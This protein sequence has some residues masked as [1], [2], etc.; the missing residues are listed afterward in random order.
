MF[1]FWLKLCR[2]E[3]LICILYYMYFSLYCPCICLRMSVTIM[4]WDVAVMSFNPTEYNIAIY[5]YIYIYNYMYNVHCTNLYIVLNRVAYTVQVMHPF[6]YINI[7]IGI[8]KVE[9]E[10]TT[11]MMTILF[12]RCH[13]DK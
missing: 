10:Q 1:P 11:T 5:T 13:C 3:P 12:L 9:E 4:F 6:I 2:I 7:Y 8:F